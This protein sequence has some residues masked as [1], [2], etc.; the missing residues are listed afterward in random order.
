M[1]LSYFCQTHL[2]IKYIR[3]D[4]CLI[5]SLANSDTKIPFRNYE[6]RGACPPDYQI[7]AFAT[8]DT[9]I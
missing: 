3:S 7:Y 5:I 2:N 4:Q 8:S 6:I 9:R 1:G